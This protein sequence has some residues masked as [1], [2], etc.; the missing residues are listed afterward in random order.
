VSLTKSVLG[1]RRLLTSRAPK[2]ESKPEDQPLSTSRL[3]LDV[4]QSKL[5]DGVVRRQDGYPHGLAD[6]KVVER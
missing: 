2:Q 3:M 5:N 6:M 4:P 1:A